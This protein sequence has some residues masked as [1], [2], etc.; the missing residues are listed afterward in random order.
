MEPKPSQLVVV[1]LGN[2]GP[3]YERT[4]HNIGFL[5]V[6][7][8]AR[9]L[10]LVLKLDK[11]FNASVAKGNI[12]GVGVH[13]VLP[14][15]YM[16]Q[17]GEAVRRYLDFY[18]LTISQLVVVSDDVA[19]PFDQL[20]LKPHGSA[21]GH[22]GLLSISQHVGSTHY[23]RLRMG[24][25]HPGQRELAEFVLSHFSSEENRH[26]ESFIDRAVNVLER[27]L[28]EDILRVMNTVN[29]KVKKQES[30]SDETKS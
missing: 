10:G 25:G 19:L 7:E 15:T 18:R 17:S 13:L 1:G 21:G 30:V 29:T 14:M 5:V 16:N 8:W 9:R 22:N 2:P 20:R 11:K 28:K 6:M 3:E 12:E 24:V 27:L 26:L 23:A 4:R